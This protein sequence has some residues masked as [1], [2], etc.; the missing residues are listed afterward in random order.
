[1]GD[2]R[3]V[4][5]GDSRGSIEPS[6]QR[7]VQ[8]VATGEGWALPPIP[9]STCRIIAHSMHVGRHVRTS[10]EAKRMF[11][12]T[13]NHDRNTYVSLGNQVPNLPVVRAEQNQ[14]TPHYVRLHQPNYRWTWTCMPSQIPQC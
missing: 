14:R 9:I 12:G 6:M 1:M 8:C 11:T 7:H 4:A 3:P 2:S 5:R 13:S 10:T